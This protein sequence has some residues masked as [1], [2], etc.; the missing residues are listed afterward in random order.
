MKWV[1]F[2]AHVPKCVSIHTV[3]VK[4]PTRCKTCLKVV[5][6]EGLPTSSLSTPGILSDG[7]LS[8]VM[9]AK[10]MQRKVQ[11]D[12]AMAA[13]PLRGDAFVIAEREQG[14]RR[15]GTAAGV[16]LRRLSFVLLLSVILVLL[17]LLLLLLLLTRA[18]VRLAADP[19]TL[20]L[21]PVKAENVRGVAEQF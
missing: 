14:A 9:I 21:T 11:H 3:F 2:F 1:T 17:L 20:R 16:A 18:T 15:C 19:T 4:K 12:L 10:L 5:P 6:Q 8:I 7:A 13:K